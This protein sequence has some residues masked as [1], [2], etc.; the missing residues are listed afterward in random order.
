MGVSSIR[1]V[2]QSPHLLWRG[3]GGGATGLLPFCPFPNVKKNIGH[4]Y[5]VTEECNS[6][7]KVVETP[8]LKFVHTL[9]VH[10]FAGN[11]AAR[12]Y[13]DSPVAPLHCALL[14]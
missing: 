2:Q 4:A 5:I 10:Q 13:A 12:F 9:N 8:G 6:E 3:G 14:L 1:A 7:T 11:S